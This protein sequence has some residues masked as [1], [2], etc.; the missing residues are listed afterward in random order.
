MAF[1]QQVCDGYSK[2]SLMGNWME[3]RLYPP[4]PFRENLTKEVLLLLHSLDPKI[5]QSPL[6]MAL[7]SKEHFLAWNAGPSGKPQTESSLMTASYQL[8]YLEKSSLSHES[9]ISTLLTAIFLQR[10]AKAL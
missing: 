3:E 6:S 10:N 4:Q 1:V 8:P 5:K 9:G 2:H 7:L